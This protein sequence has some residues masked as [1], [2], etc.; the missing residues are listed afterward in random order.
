MASWCCRGPWRVH[1]RRTSLRLQRGHASRD[2][3]CLPG[4]SGF[5]WRPVS[6]DDSGGE[7]SA[8]VKSV[9]SIQVS[10]CAHALGACRSTEV[11]PPR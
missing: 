1:C 2:T 11:M 9:P 4:T 6:A 10:I 5:Y 8:C 7:S 3:H